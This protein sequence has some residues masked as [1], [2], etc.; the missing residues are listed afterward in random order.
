MY[1][2]IFVQILGIITLIISVISM[3][4]RKKENFLLIQ[5]VGTLLF[6]L[7]YILTEKY[8]GAILFSI[9]LIRGLVYY[10]YKKKNLKPSLK[11]LVIFQVALIISTYFSWQNILSIIPF[12]ATVSKTW[13]TW[14]D[15]MKW[16]RRT[17]LL[18]QGIMIIYNISAAMYTGA[19][20]EVCNSI[21]SI[22]AIWRYDIRKVKSQE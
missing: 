16:V 21:S 9:T 3:Q 6:I 20:T 10:Y 17:S 13:G 8:T 1:N 2:L 22:I 5:T 14:Q 12:I 7:Q 11:I 15:D 19:I 18:A 4:Q